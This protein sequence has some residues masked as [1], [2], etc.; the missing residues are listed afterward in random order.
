MSEII[1]EPNMD[2]NEPILIDQSLLDFVESS[3]S[4]LLEITNCLSLFLEF[5]VQEEHGLVP[6]ALIFNPLASDCAIWIDQGKA[7]GKARTKSAIEKLSE[8]KGWLETSNVEDLSEQQVTIIKTR[9]RDHSGPLYHL[10]SDWTCPAFVPPQVLV[11]A[12]F[13]SKAT[14]LF[15]P[16]AECRRLGL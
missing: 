6:A 13:R 2:K 15:Q 11:S 5:D 4:A 12:T 9:L 3:G 1:D 8:V 14:G 16:N 10:V 7:Y